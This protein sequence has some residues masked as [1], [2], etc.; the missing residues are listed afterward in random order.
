MSRFYLYIGISLLFLVITMT[1]TSL[2]IL[3]DRTQV[4]NQLSN[5][6]EKQAS[7]SSAIFVGREQQNKVEVEYFSGLAMLEKAIVSNDYAPLDDVFMQL[8]RRKSSIMHIRILNLAGQEI[9]R[10]DDRLDAPTRIPNAELQNKSSRYYTKELLETPLDHTYMSPIDLNV[11]HGV[12]E[13]NHRPVLR[14]A[15]KIVN[16]ETQEI[17]GA[18]VFN[19]NLN[20]LF[21]IVSASIPDQMDWYLIDENG[22]FIVNPDT[23]KLY[24]L[25]LGC[26]AFHDGQVF[27]SKNRN[28]YHGHL[29]SVV[30]IKS[31]A[32]VKGTD[33]Q[34]IVNYKPNYEPELTTPQSVLMVLLTNTLWWI[35]LFITGVVLILCCALYER[36]QQQF[37]DTINR[38]KMKSVLESVTQMLERL[39]END[40]PTTGRH[41]QR[42]AVY[43]RLMAEHLALDKQL[44]ADIYQFASLHDIGKISTPDHIL[45]KPGKLDAQEWQVM[46]QHVENGYQLLHEFNL[47]P[48]AE[49]IARFHHERWDGNG[50]PRRI[51]GEDIPIE[52]RIVSLVDCFDALR[53]ERPYKKAFS[54]EKSQVIIN[55]LKG[56]AFDPNL[57][58]LFNSLEDEFRL[59]KEDNVT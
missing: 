1:F 23:S 52:A 39:N 18:L 33:F 20:R 51:A 15:K 27:N 4:V 57:V 19:Y 40:D 34:L 59:M 11:E 21:Q 10:V 32:G 5:N 50:Y 56:S 42:V 55:E 9:F 7:I 2:Y 28:Y 53:S 47:S 26:S 12:I 37:I 3:D 25:Q 17:L 49:N 13:K 24:C 48:V 41:V 8:M 36:Y 46:Q 6:I 38:E 16:H 22:Q 35:V 14:V 30:N 43:S 45:K 58:D 54:F 31:E 44:I 29:A